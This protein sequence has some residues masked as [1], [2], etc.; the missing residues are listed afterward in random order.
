MMRRVRRQHKS[1]TINQKS[2]ISCYFQVEKFKADGTITYKGP[3]FHNTILDVGL[4]LFA[5]DD[6][7][8]I[9]RYCNVGSGSS[10]P[11]QGQSGLD[12]FVASVEDS[13]ENIY[14]VSHHTT[15]TDPLH[16]GKEETREFSIGT[17]TGNLT[18]VGLSKESNSDY[19]N[20]QLFRDVSDNPITITV[21]S[22][23]GLRVTF[24]I[25]V[26][27]IMERGVSYPGSFDLDGVSQSFNQVINHEVFNEYNDSDYSAVP[28]RY[29]S[30]DSVIGWIDDG[31][32]TYIASEGSTGTVCDTYTPDAYLSGNFYRDTPL[33][34]SPNTYVGDFS[35]IMIGYDGSGDK[36]A[37]LSTFLLDSAITLLDTEELTI[38]LRR[39]WGRYDEYS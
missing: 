39:S 27:T 16:Y 25:K 15:N 24:D 35:R 11:V 7:Y 1:Y 28:H 18:E 13:E 36:E 5:N 8:R 30:G 20:R 9:I 2:L 23:E 19:F 21:A 6:L 22:D 3:K 4:D 33:I 29:L 37:V 38:N 26:Y 12:S 14:S 31:S 34:W 10:T 32:T 17:C